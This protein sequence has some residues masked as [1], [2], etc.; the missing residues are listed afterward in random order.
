MYKDFE[1]HGVN[2]SGLN[3]KTFENVSQRLQVEKA[4]ASV[5][6]GDEVMSQSSLSDEDD[7]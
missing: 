7:E 3:S 5:M 4:T 1:L 2:H 6:H